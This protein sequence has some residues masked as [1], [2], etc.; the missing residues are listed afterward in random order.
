MTW[1]S[2]GKNFSRAEMASLMRYC[3]EQGITTFD[4]ADIYGGYTNEADFGEAFADSGIS[5]DKIQLITKC[6]IQYVCEARDNRI[7]HYD[8]SKEYIVWSAETSLKHL[9]TDYLD[10]FLL[11]R[12][13]PLM[14]PEEVAEAIE[15][16]RKQGKIQHFGLSNFTPSQVA[17][18]ESAI[19]VA[20]NQVEVSLTANDALYDGTLDDCLAHQRLAMAWSPLG[21]YF[22]EQ[23]DKQARI[24]LVMERLTEKYRASE[25][26]L[27]LAWLL[28]HP[29]YI[30]PVVGTTDRERLTACITA[31]GIALETEDW[32]E[33]LTASQGH[34]VP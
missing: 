27:L 13:S 23:D 15:T 31:A 11:H 14:Q 21:S 5:R 32:F 9:K 20:G 7:K 8:Y 12:P 16:L 25:L 30:F 2:W 1:G 17:L 33:L 28:K 24:R 10:L 18:I 3:L 22:R 29:A 19:P 4:H 6:G 34:K 26:Q